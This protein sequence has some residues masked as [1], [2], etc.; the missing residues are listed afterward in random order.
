[1]DHLEITASWLPALVSLGQLNI[2]GWVYLGLGLGVALFALGYQ[3]RQRLRAK[4]RGVPT[5]NSR[6][7][8]APGQARVD[9]KQ[10]PGMP[11]QDS[12]LPSPQRSW[13][14]ALSIVA[15]ISILFGILLLVGVKFL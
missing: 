6:K 1:M 7:P 13:M 4:R 9:S 8:I 12:S 10:A 15:V 2:Y 3:S 11:P 14:Q 5:N